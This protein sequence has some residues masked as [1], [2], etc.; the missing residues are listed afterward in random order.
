M[1]T[2]LRALAGTGLILGSFAVAYVPVVHAASTETTG[3][4]MANSAITA[5][6]KAA[7]LA[8]KGLDSNDISVQ[9]TGNVVTLTGTVDN[10]AQVQLAE[11]V[12]AG[13]D[14]VNQ[15][16]NNLQSSQ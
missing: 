9:T 15:V 4:Y 2:L 13:V 14:G 16:Q 10:S 11:Q 3:Q 7:L 1:K 12:A 6:V 8:T 5:K